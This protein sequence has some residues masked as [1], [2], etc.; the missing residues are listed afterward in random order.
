MRRGWFQWQE[1]VGGR[2]KV[3]ERERRDRERESE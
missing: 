2:E 3:I 1:K